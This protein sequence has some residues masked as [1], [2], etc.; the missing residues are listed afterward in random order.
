MVV[1]VVVIVVVIV[2]VIVRSHGASPVWKTSTAAIHLSAITEAQCG[3]ALSVMAGL[4]PAIHAGAQRVDPR[5]KPG[6]DD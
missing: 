1:R 3:L 5:D 6:D 2:G 4:V